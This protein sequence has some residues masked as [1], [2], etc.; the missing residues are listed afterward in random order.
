MTALRSPLYLAGSR[1]APCSLR[2]RDVCRDERETV[3]P[4][5]LRDSHTGRSI[6]ASDLS[7][8]DGCARCHDV[9]DRR[10]RL[11]SGLLLSD[12][13]WLFYALR[14]LQET[15]ERRKDMKLL[16]VVGDADLQPRREP[17]PTVRKPRG[18]RREVPKG[19]PLKSANN[20]P[21]KGEMKFRSR[22][23]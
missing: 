16:T 4:C 15:L 13:E 5:H 6:K 23:K 20:L 22:A 12:E 14:G 9:F 17:K 11:P 10:V 21:K 3:V 19:K 7:V 1:G 18:E 2:I 8:A